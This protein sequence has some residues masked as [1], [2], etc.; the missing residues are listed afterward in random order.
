MDV[1]SQCHGSLIAFEGPQDAI[2]TQ[3]RLLPSSPNILI[4]PPLQQ[5]MKEEDPE[6]PFHAQ[7]HIL[8]VHNACSDR[9][10][11]ARSFLQN[12]TPRNKRLVFMNGGTASA[13]MEC[14]SDI[15][16][17]LTD[18]DF[19]KAERIFN[20]LVRNGASGLQSRYTTNVDIETSQIIL[21]RPQPSDQDGEITSDPV[22]EAMRAADALD[23]QTASLQPNNDIDLT[24]TTRSR[25][26]SVPTYR[27]VDDFQNATPFYVF[28]ARKW[29]GRNTRDSDS[30]QTPR[31]SH[32]TADL[33]KTT[34][35]VLEPAGS[36]MNELD[37]QPGSPDSPEEERPKS[38]LSPASLDLSSPRSF[39]LEST[40][41][42]PSICEAFAVQVRPSATT[43]SHKKIRPVDRIYSSA[44]RNQDILLC[45]FPEPPRSRPQSLDVSLGVRQDKLTP[46]SKFATEIPRPTFSTPKRSIVRRNPPSPLRLQKAP[47]RPATYVD[48]GTNPRNSYVDRG[49][50][51]ESE[52]SGGISKSDMRDSVSLYIETPAEADPH[53]TYEPI[54][55]MVENL[56]I[57][58]KSGK[59]DPRLEATI[60]SFREGKYPIYKS[61]SEPEAKRT[62]HQSSPS[63]EQD[64]E[65]V[66]PDNK[67]HSCAK[68]EVVPACHIDSDDYDP[69]A[70]E[71]YPHP[72]RPWP[73]KPD[74]N[75]HRP[76]TPPTPAQTPPLAI[77]KLERRFHD[78]TTTDCRTAVCMQNSL[79]SILNIYFP[80]EDAGYHQFNFPLLPELSSLWKPVFREADSDTAVQRK[81][82]VDLI[83]GIGAQQGV[84]RE[85]L[86]AISG[87]LEK[88]GTKPNGVSR[89]GRLDLRFLIANAMQAFTAQPLTNQTQDNPFSN[90]LL[91]A[92]LIIPHLETYMAAH[93]AT[94]FLLL[95]YPPEHLST[96]L[97]LQRLVGVDLLKVAGILY[98]GDA[99]PQP[100][101]GFKVPP[102][103][104]THPRTGSGPGI[105]RST[106]RSGATLLAPTR[107]KHHR[108]RE[109]P[110]PFAKANF[111]LTSSA[112]ESEIATLISTIWKILIDISPFYIPEGMASTRASTHGERDAKSET[113]GQGRPLAQTPLINASRQ[114]ASLT[115]A[116]A[117]MGFRRQGVGD[118]DAPAEYNSGIVYT[119]TN[120]PPLPPKHRPSPSTPTPTP[121]PTPTSSQS[122]S[123]PSPPSIPPPSLQA[124]LPQPKPVK[125][126][127]SSVTST[128]TTR[129]QRNKLRS[130]LGRE[131]DGDEV[132]EWES[133]WD[134]EDARLAAEARKY[135]PLY[136]RRS[137]PRKG[138]SRKALKWLGLA[139]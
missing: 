130:I 107:S 82:K 56:V 46:R 112:N 134:E 122:P 89:S 6:T 137:G 126:S 68:H 8:A 28:G 9:A 93:S 42:T 66:V 120:P 64:P 96:V 81:R 80:P 111:L 118:D 95:E 63:S 79:R 71:K 52:P 53:E 34:K 90:P 58:F 110:P 57:F 23:L 20:R 115:G 1:M 100:Y 94:R 51:T 37:N 45:S 72:S 50:I 17:H 103:T 27:V 47:L 14:I 128:R 69:F 36:R 2:S 65:S 13:Q 123:P 55:P 7:S 75:N 25:S 131:P 119:D 86:G 91:L 132:W 48:R 70:Y 129:S 11:V 3:L 77:E 109:T 138:S 78:F 101:P 88:L 97:A 76:S 32:T 49:T 61:P 83:L 98:S 41:N 105:L 19:S 33:R 26:T 4:I 124:P 99:S 5:F 87:S 74:S 73:F 62:S 127:K 30:P 60:Q 59:N 106:T 121:T 10:E 139:T 125:S 113:H 135:M 18:G 21:A 136:G 35:R 116:S 108:R 22:S 67:R 38:K 84:D 15:S 16:K 40:L 31:R 114:P 44:I 117:I 54:L 85:F 24:N 92:T 102:R 133:C 39:K 12:S 104:A 29:Q 43:A